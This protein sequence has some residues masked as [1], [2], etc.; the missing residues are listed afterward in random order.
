N[1]SRMVLDV[2]ASAVLRDE[3]IVEL[4]AIATKDESLTWAQRSLP[5]KNTL[6][7]ADAEAVEQAFR[8]RMRS[9]ERTEV[10]LATLPAPSGD[11][12]ERLDDRPRPSAAS[13]D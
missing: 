1:N 12:S 2:D 7:S 5:A 9:F 3:L 4:A 6:T 13:S 10:D 8:A 11:G